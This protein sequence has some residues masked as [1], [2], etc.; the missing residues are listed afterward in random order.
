MRNFYFAIFMLS[1]V[2]LLFGVGMP[3]NSELLLVDKLVLRPESWEVSLSSDQKIFRNATNQEAKAKIL[4]V[5]RAHRPSDFDWSV[6]SIF[7]SSAVLSF[8]GWRREIWFS[9]IGQPTSR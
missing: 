8:V 4:A 6:L 2:C 5:L 7:I 3:L 1:V 9:K